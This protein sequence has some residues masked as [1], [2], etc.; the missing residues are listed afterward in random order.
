MVKAHVGRWSEDCPEHSGVVVLNM[1]DVPLGFGVTARGTVD[2]R[3]LD[4]TGV[5]VFRQ[6]DVGEYLRGEDSLFTT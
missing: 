6:G 3:K 1:D 4:P 5:V 2:A